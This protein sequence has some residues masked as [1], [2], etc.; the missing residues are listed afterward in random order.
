MVECQLD[1]KGVII[2]SLIIPKHNV[3]VSILTYSPTASE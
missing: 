2:L 3:S 1:V